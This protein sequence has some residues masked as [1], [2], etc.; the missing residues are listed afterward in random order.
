MLSLEDFVNG[1]GPPQPPPAGAPL[2]LNLPSLFEVSNTTNR[3]PRAP[4]SNF[5]EPVPDNAPPYT[6]FHNNGQIGNDLFGSQAA[7]REGK[8]KTQ[9]A[10]DDF[11]YE[12]PEDI[13]KLELGDGLLQTLDTEAEDLLDS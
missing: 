8:T 2:N 3:L 1:G 7:V 12:M 9:Q 4:C 11:L 6:G 5:F 13:P 10:V